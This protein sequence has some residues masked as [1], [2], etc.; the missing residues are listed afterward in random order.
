MLFRVKVSFGKG[1]QK[2]AVDENQCLG[3]NKRVWPLAIL[4]LKDSFL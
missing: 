4:V 1:Y 2:E 3:Y